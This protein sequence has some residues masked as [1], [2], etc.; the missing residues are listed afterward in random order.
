MGMDFNDGRWARVKENSVRWWAGELERPLIR[1]V[2]GGHDPGRP[3]PALPGYQFASFYDFSVPAADIV[4]RWDYNLSCLKYM[5]DAFPTIQ[6]L[7]GT[8]IVAA[9]LGA[10]SENRDGTVWM[11]P[12]QELEIADIHFEYDPDNCWLKRMRELYRAAMDRWHGEVLLGMAELGG[13]LDIL[14]TFRPGEKLLTDLYDHPDE[15]KRL[16]WEIHDLW[17]R[18]YD[19]FNCLLQPENPGY[20]DWGEI[21]SDRP[22]FML[23]C[24]FAYMI[25]PE[26]FDEFVKPELAASCRRLT[27]AFYHLDGPGQVPHLDSILT[28]PDL[29]GV[30]WIPGRGSPDSKQWPEVFRKIREAGKLVQIFAGETDVL[31]VIAGQLGSA[32]GVHYFA[33]PGEGYRGYDEVEARELLK[34]YGVE[35]A[36]GD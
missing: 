7:L 36:E 15:V 32:M 11:H 2:T 17:W 16:T 25:G 5:G 30:Q 4:D 10:V 1:V 35:E 33:C 19:E 34:R 22:T 26:M 20:S 27:N 29:D 23:Q 24:D 18:Y 3:E 21:Y 13:T 6:P 9:F 31:D 14:S 8:G 12:P 28:I